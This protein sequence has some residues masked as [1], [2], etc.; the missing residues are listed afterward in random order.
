MINFN[1]LAVVAC[2]LIACC[3]P[4]VNAIDNSGFEDGNFNYWSLVYNYARISTEARTGS[5]SA[6]LY[7]DSPAGYPENIWRNDLDNT[8]L[9]V[10]LWYKVENFVTVE[11]DPFLVI[12]LQLYDYDYINYTVT[13]V[14]LNTS[15]GWHYAENTDLSFMYEGYDDP[16]ELDIVI[17]SHIGSTH[18]DVYIDD[19]QYVTPTPTPTPTPTATP[20]PTPT[21]QAQ[22]CGNLSFTTIERD[23]NYINWYWNISQNITSLSV[24]SHLIPDFDNTT[25]NYFLSDLEPNTPHAIKI[26]SINDS[27]CN[28]TYTSGKTATSADN[29]TDTINKY[30]IFLLGV[31]CIIIGAF[32]PPVGLSAA[33]FGVLG[34]ITPANDMIMILLYLIL[35]IVGI[36]EIV[37]GEE[38]V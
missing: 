34:W 32:I 22:G 4:M 1:K 2:L 7:N 38:W 24:D 20:T 3:I 31:I 37:I 23:N 26:N 14:F 13:R 10:S 9:G 28:I 35:V 25:N 17:T 12:D 36:L 29:L 21:T 30:L 19:I 27:A 16:V 15:P 18:G 5:Y 33:L 11:N 8:L 6:V